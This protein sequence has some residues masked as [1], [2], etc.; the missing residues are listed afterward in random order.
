MSPTEELHIDAKVPRLSIRRKR[1]TCQFVYKGRAGNSTDSINSMF[2]LVSEHHDR[3][4]RSSKT[5]LLYIPSVSL[6]LCKGNIRHRGAIQYNSL[7][8]DLRNADS[9]EA[10]K[11]RIKVNVI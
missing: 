4:T 8:P 1:H 10:F 3:H 6:E 2:T 9:Y 11:K 7:D 5:D